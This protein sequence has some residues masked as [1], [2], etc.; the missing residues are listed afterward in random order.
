MLGV[1]VPVLVLSP[2]PLFLRLSLPPSDNADEGA[3]D[4]ALLPYRPPSLPR[5]AKAFCSDV[6]APNPASMSTVISTPTGSFPENDT[7]TG[8]IRSPFCKTSHPVVSSSS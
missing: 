6:L 3:G 7:R 8:T 2:I 4:G 5:P 1:S